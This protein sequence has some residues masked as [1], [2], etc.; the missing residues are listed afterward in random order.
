MSEAGRYEQVIEALFFRYY[1]EG[2]DYFR[3]EKDEL[4]AI[5]DELG[6]VVRNIP[7]IIY[8]F[9][10]R[11]GLPTSITA[12]GHWA[13]EA[14]GTNAYAFRRLRNPP[15][16]A[17]PFHAYA[18]ID[19]DNALPELVQRLL[20]EDEQSLLTRILYNRLVDIFTGLTCYHIQNHY[21][22]NVRDIGQ[23][24][25]DAVYVGIDEAGKLSVI[26]IEAKGRQESE[27]IGRVQ[28]S[29]MARL[30][31]QAFPRL[32]RRLLAVKALDDGTVAFVEFDDHEEPD[33]FGI[34][35]VRRY[36][37]VRHV[38]EDKG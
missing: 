16:F 29:Q 9:R 20:R 5:C 32:A 3:F 34:V 24:E 31:R 8:A 14:A 10:G 21:R 25:V 19:I 2:L 1:H 6:I 38:D 12:T 13:I 26:P 28:I 11:R 7:D 22:A 35:A 27:M 37:L 15:Q 33:D 36:R 17:I 4:A 30:A 18:P 23:V